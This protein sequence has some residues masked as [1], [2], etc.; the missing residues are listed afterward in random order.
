[1]EWIVQKKNKQMCKKYQEITAHCDSMQEK[2]MV[3]QQKAPKLY[4]KMIHIGKSE[5]L[6]NKCRKANRYLK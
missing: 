2:L 4:T 6:Y 5:N 3:I 1:M